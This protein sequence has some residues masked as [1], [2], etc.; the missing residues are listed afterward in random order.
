MA[1]LRRVDSADGTLE[2]VSRNGRLRVE[3]L[4]D[5]V[6]RIR[7]TSADAFSP[8]PPAGALPESLVVTPAEVAE[9]ELEPAP[10]SKTPPIATLT[11][12]AGSFAIRLDTGAWEI[13]DSGGLRV[14]GSSSPIEFDASAAAARTSLRLDLAAHEMVFGQGEG[15]GPLNRRGLVREF[16]NIDVLGHAPA[17]HPGLQSL[18]VSIPFAVTLQH[19]RAA[20]W[21][22]DSA[23]RQRWDVGQSD[24]DA[25]LLSAETSELDLYVFLGPTV[26]GVV[27][28]FTALTGRVPLPP[29]WALGYQQCRYSYETREQLETVARELRRRQLPCDVLYLDI[30]H[31][32]GYRVFTFGK[33]FPKPAEMLEGLRKKGFKTVSIVDPGVKNDPRF[34]VLQRGVA[35]DAFVKTADGS[36]DYL[37]EVWPGESRFPDFLNAKTREWWGREQSHLSRLGIDGIWNDMNEPANFARPDK[38]LAPDALHDTAAGPR[39]HAEVHNL[40]GQAMAQASRDGLLAHARLPGRRAGSKSGAAAAIPRPFVVTRAGYAGI[41]RHAIVWT[42]DNSSNWEHL[43]DA[44]PSLLNL[45]LSGVA[46][47][48]ADV[49]GFLGV[50]TAEL[51]TRWFQF[52]AFTPFFR[53]HTNIGTPA[54]EPWAFGPAAEEVCRMYLHLRYQLLPYFYSL[55]ANARISGAPWMRPMFWHYANDPVAA[56]CEDQF[57]VGSDLLVAPVTQP[58]AQARCVYLP[59]DLWFDFWTGEPLPGGR[60]IV[61]QSPME[62]VPLYVRAG[63]IVPMESVNQHTAPYPKG[64][65]SLHCWPRGRGELSWHEDDGV[66]EAYHTGAVCRRKIHSRTRGRTLELHFEPELGSWSSTVNTWRLILWGARSAG[67]LTVNGT[68]FP[69]SFD[70]DGGVCIAEIPNSPGEMLVRFSGLAS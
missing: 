64:T 68:A 41:Q 10:K 33:A 15:T 58:G 51:F 30:H 6:Y 14:T 70:A 66:S 63:A 35:A 65:V 56:T 46:L 18:Y 62:Q 26:A 57:L 29:R 32:D 13:T 27:E 4:G 53:N 47:C 38:T 54:Q 21:F 17:I 40:Y 24:R 60:H 28:D 69:G 49:G 12:A 36:A 42:G 48:G 59:N 37:G 2:L 3:A 50:P 9:L 39:R 43:R 19:G 67:G 5:Q 22:W 61:A 20:G 34:G 44:I 8:N 52:A 11:T 55:V 7:A 31:L 16:W 1:R 23:S 25:A 45:S